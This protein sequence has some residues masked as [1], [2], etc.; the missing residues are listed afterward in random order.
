MLETSNATPGKSNNFEHGTIPG[1]S[2]GETLPTVQWT[3]IVEDRTL[4]LGDCMLPLSR[5]DMM[6]ILWARF[7]H[8][9]TWWQTR[10]DRLSNEAHAMAERRGIP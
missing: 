9:A 6:E 3:Q 8:L 7:M 1:R 10:P 4:G 5:L 2:V